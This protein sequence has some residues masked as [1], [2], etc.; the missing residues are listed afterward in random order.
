MVWSKIALD[1]II[2]RAHRFG[3]EKKLIAYLMVAIGT[4]DVL[5]VDHGFAKG[6]LLY[7]FLSNPTNQGMSY[8]D[9]LTWITF[10]T[11]FTETAIAEAM[12]TGVFPLE[13]DEEVAEEDMTSGSKSKSRNFE[14]TQRTMGESKAA[15]N[16]LGKVDFSPISHGG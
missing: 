11:A 8:V 9:P 16:Q 13:I 15:E 14:K 12:D 1:Q 4:V 10:S 2:G 6:S 3:Q 7:D 5:M